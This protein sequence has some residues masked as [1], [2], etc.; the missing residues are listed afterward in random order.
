MVLGEMSPVSFAVRR[1]SGEL[2][3][4]TVTAIRDTDATGRGLSLIHI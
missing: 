1:L 3:A 2:A 4:A